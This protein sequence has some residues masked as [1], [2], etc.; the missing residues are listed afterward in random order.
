MK[1]QTKMKAMGNITINDILCFTNG[2]IIASSTKNT[3]GVYLK[4]PSFA[5]T[6]CE[7][8]QPSE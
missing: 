8:Q 6:A 7:Q 4:Y 3:S 2:A 5:N 1:F